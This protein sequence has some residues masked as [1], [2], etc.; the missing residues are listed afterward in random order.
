MSNILFVSNWNLLKNYFVEISDQYLDTPLMVSSFNELNLI[1]PDTSFGIVILDCTKGDE[2]ANAQAIS[3][4]KERFNGVPVWAF[5]D[6]EQIS[7]IPLLIGMGYQNFIGEWQ[8]TFETASILNA[9]ARGIRLCSVQFL[10]RFSLQSRSS[11][12]RISNLFKSLPAREIQVLFYLKE[13]MQNKEIATELGLAEA[14]VKLHIKNLCRKFEVH[15]RTAMLAI[16]FGNGFF[17]KYSPIK[18]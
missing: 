6:E 13:G 10:E 4:I 8:N 16:A 5:L 15:N 7:S 2:N 11:D 3:I 12:Y 14:T 18:S 17:D 9:G 1:N